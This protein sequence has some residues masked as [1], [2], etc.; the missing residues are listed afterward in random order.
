MISPTKFKKKK[1][2][3][4]KKQEYNPQHVSMEEERK[5]T[6]WRARYDI[7]FESEDSSQ[8]SDNNAR[9][10]NHAKIVAFVQ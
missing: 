7:T 2:K 9:V 10:F 5:K 1:K 3:K 8:A 6:S 4:K